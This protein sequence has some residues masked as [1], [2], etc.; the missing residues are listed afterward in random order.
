MSLVLSCILLIYN[1]TFQV[2]NF[3]SHSRLIHLLAIS[4]DQLHKIWALRA[5]NNQS[6][7]QFMLVDKIFNI[8]GKEEIVCVVESQWWGFLIRLITENTFWVLHFLALTHLLTRLSFYRTK[9]G[10]VFLNLR[11]FRSGSAGKF[12]YLFPENVNFVANG[13]N[14]FAWLSWFLDQVR[15]FLLSSCCLL[16]ANPYRCPKNKFIVVF[17]FMSL[18]DSA[19]TQDNLLTELVLI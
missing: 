14:G 5:I 4:G 7:I 2:I 9:R 6:D 3:A 18:H 19:D 11:R 17:N 15:K 12:L 13:M 16:A 8:L 10:F 1:L